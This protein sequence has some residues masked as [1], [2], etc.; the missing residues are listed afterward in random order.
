MKELLERTREVLI[1]AVLLD[2]D[3]VDDIIKV[4]RERLG[5]DSSYFVSGGCNEFVL[6]LGTFLEKYGPVTYWSYG[7]DKEPDVHMALEYQGSVF[8]IG[9][10]STLDTISSRGD[11][12]FDTQDDARWV[13]VKKEDVPTYRLGRYENSNKFESIYLA[14]VKWNYIVPGQ[15]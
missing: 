3:T 2:A 6:E 13:R 11:F 7:S 8:D 10:A 4:Y 9:G 14:G 12:Y 15:N 1:E 5:D